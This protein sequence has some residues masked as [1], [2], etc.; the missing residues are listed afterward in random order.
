MK[1]ERDYPS[2]S[3][4]SFIKNNTNICKF[5]SIFFFFFAELALSILEIRD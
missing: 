2:W 1:W 4:D 3:A 5:G